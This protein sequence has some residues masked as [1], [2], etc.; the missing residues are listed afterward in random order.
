MIIAVVSDT[1][2]NNHVLDKIL[3]ETNFA[4]VIFHLGDNVKDALYLKEKFKGEV[5]YVKGNCDIAV[6]GEEDNLVEL[7]GKRFF[8]THGHRY[9]VKYDLN[10]LYFKAKELNAD[11]ALYGHS[12]VKVIE[13]YNGVYIMNPGSASLPRDGSRSIGFINIEEGKISLKVK[14]I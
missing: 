5:Y 11:V 12:H 14:N 10:N 9:G 3:E 8:L 6:S 2:F 13:E 7:E 1:H 4:D